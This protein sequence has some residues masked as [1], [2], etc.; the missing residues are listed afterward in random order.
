MNIETIEEC[1]ALSLAGKIA[2]PEVV[3]RLAATGVERYRIDM[4]GRTKS[5]YGLAGE[6][7]VAPFDVEGPS[8]PPQFDVGAVREAI[9]ASQRQE[10]DYR[11]FLR[12][13]MEAGCSHYEVFL[14]GRKAVYIGRNGGEH[15]E[16]FP[17][18]L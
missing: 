12:R 17:G 1:T 2:F 14:T 13:V 5:A 16:P 10:I 3:R 4:V 11:T 8:I 15:V 9:G 7:H 18:A 6:S